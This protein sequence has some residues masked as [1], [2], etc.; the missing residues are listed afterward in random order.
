MCS[1]NLTRRLSK[2]V[3]AG[4]MLADLTFSDLGISRVGHQV[5]FTTSC[6]LYPASHQ[7]AD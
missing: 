2:R 3:T 1:C 5:G 4:P 6:P 7:G